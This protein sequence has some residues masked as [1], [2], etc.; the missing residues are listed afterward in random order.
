MHYKKFEVGCECVQV[1]WEL[2][3]KNKKQKINQPIN[4]NADQDANNLNVKHSM[5]TKREGLF[6]NTVISAVKCQLQIQQ[7][8]SEPL[9]EYKISINTW[10]DCDSIWRIYPMWYCCRSASLNNNMLTKWANSTCDERQSLNILGNSYFLSHRVRW[11][12]WHQHICLPLNISCDFTG[13][14][15]KNKNGY[16]M[17]P[18]RCW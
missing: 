1:G 17:L 16:N 4:R 15:E 14:F 10:C 12:D 18:E 6:N 2:Q 3:T 13:D 7:V 5:T 11:E 8:S 9:L